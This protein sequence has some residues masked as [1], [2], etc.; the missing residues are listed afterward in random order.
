MRLIWIGLFWLAAALPARAEPIHIVAFG[1]SNTAGFRVLNKN[2]YPAQLEAALRAKGYDVQVL[3]SGV[4]GETSSMGLSRFDRSIPKNTNVAIVYFGRN[5]LRWGIE[6]RK[7]RANIGA[8][9]PA[10]IP[11]STPSIVST[12][13]RPMVYAGPSFSDVSGTTVAMLSGY[14]ADDGLPSGTLT[15]TWSQISGPNTATLSATTGET[16]ITASG[17]VNGTYVF[18]LTATDGTLTSTSDATITILV[19]HPRIWLTSAMLTALSA[20][21]AGGDA[22]WLTLK[23]NADAYITQAIPKLTITGATNASPAVFTATETIPWTGTTTMLVGGASGAWAAINANG[24]TSWTATRTGTH[25]FTIPIDSSAFGS[26][27]G[28]APIM[29]ATNNL[30]VGYITYGAA[31]GWYD[32]LLQLSLA[33]LMTSTTSYKTKALEIVD[34]EASIGNSG[35]IDPISSDSWRDAGSTYGLAIAYDWLYSSLSPTQITNVTNCLNLWQPLKAVND[36]NGVNQPASNY[37]AM[38]LRATG[39]AGYATQGDNTLAPTWIDFALGQWNTYGVPAWGVPSSNPQQDNTGMWESGM[40]GIGYYGSNDFE[41]QSEYILM[42]LT[43]TGIDIGSDYRQRIV[44]AIVHSHRPNG[45][46]V[47]P[48]RGQWNSTCSRVESADARLLTAYT[49]AGTTEGEWAQWMYQHAATNV[50]AGCLAQVASNPQNTFLFYRAANTATDPT[51]TQPTYYDAIGGSATIFWRTGW[52]TSDQ[53]TTYAYGNVLY[54]DAGKPKMVGSIGITRGADTLIENAG[55]AQGTADGLTGT[56]DLEGPTKSAFASTLF[57]WDGG[58]GSGGQCFTQDDSYTGCQ[59]FWGRPA[60]QKVKLASAYGYVEADHTNAYDF[61]NIPASRT[62]TAWFRS[63][64]SLGAGNY[65]VWDRIRS[66]ATT[67]TKDIRWQLQGATGG[68]PSVSGQVVSDSV[69]SS[70]LYI[71]ALNTSSTVAVSQNNRGTGNVNYYAS[72]TPAS[73]ANNYDLMTYIYAGASGATKPVTTMLGT[74]DTNFVGVQIADSTPRVAVSPKTLTPSGS[75][76]LSPTYT[77]T[78]FTT[79]HS[80]TGNYLVSGMVAGFYAI[81]GPSSTSCTVGA[82]GTCYFTSASGAITIGAGAPGAGGT[83]MGGKTVTGG[84]VIHE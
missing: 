30:D 35:I 21:V 56:P 5:D 78:S 75:V 59:G 20:K 52:S 12:N 65:V 23:A 6:P 37:W 72:F 25:T 64:M 4:S 1:D 39:S 46:E 33:Y 68:T 53:F 22:D 29:F 70:K 19:P 79:T 11:G 47:G 77:T 73:A 10:D 50:P 9:Q 32:Q 83:T 7:F 58:T 66:T 8:I 45:W 24:S 74:I 81:S 84:K 41:R 2:A 28:Q 49:I 13:K 17:L 51:L 71:E 42:V 36:V 80:G 57:Y 18:R 44:K 76:Y 34:W 31:G 27:S 15:T 62:L 38:L 67:T 3:N 16:I 69:G 63:Y 54:G 48:M 55:W 26:F 43:A 14:A 60:A 82:D 40:N 61:N